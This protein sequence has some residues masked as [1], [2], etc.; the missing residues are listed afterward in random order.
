MPAQQYRQG[1]AGGT[2]GRGGAWSARELIQLADDNLRPSEAADNKN[3][4]RLTPAVVAG[5]E[6]ELDVLA[7]VFV[8]SAQRYSSPSQS[9]RG[10]VPR[11]DRHERA[12]SDDRREPCAQGV[13][14][15]FRPRSR[16][17]W[18]VGCCHV[19]MAVKAAAR[20][21]DSRQGSK[22]ASHPPPTPAPVTS[23]SAASATTA[24]RLLLA[25]GET[26]YTKCSAR[27]GQADAR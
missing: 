5:I 10:P 23:D 24:A 3:A 6:Q 21:Y 1:G 26:K 20:T 17:C 4:E 8:I 15:G 18:M 7:G 25:R 16:S 9:D 12:T 27:G 19:G 2:E 14:L 11:T 22:E 13:E